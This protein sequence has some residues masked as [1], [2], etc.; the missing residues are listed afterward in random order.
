MRVVTCG[1]VH[2]ESHLP[3]V[4]TVQVQRWSVV[5]REQVLVELEAAIKFSENV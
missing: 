1:D 4:A 2:T 5:E 3:D